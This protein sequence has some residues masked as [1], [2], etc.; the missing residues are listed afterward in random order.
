MAISL[1]AELP[2]PPLLRRAARAFLVLLGILLA[3]AG[4]LAATPLLM[5][6]IAVLILPGQADFSDIDRDGMVTLLACTLIAAVALPLGVRLVRGRRTLVLFLRRFGFEGSS[7]A[8]SFAVGTAVG[9]RWRLITLDDAETAPVGVSMRARRTVGLFRIVAGAVFLG[10]LGYAAAW[11][12]GSGPGAI[13][14]QLFR[15]IHEG[16]VARGDNPVAALF[17]ALIAALVIGVAVLAIVFTLILLPTAALGTAA[18]FSWGSWRAV[19]KAERA[20][21]LEV[22]TPEEIE[23]QVTR[24]ARRARAVFAPRLVVLRAASAVWRQVVRRL[25]GSV[26]AVVVDVSVPSENLLWEI[27]TLRPGARARWITVGARDRLEPLASGGVT[28][29][30]PALADRFRTALDGEQVLVYAGTTSADLVRFARSLRVRLERVQQPDSRA[31][32]AS[33][34]ERNP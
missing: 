3:L 31:A 13:V 28:A 10:V 11:I 23:P 15:S 30:D 29:L 9:R 12:H 8:L 21:A 5:V 1:I 2:P 26:G 22:T 20:K 4:L 18:L 25:A 14:E 27:E 7:R 17:G 33:T 6:L 19:R 16:A 32:V 24:A 34:Q